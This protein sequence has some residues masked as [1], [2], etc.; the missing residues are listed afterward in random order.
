MERNPEIERCIEELKRRIDMHDLADR[1]GL[2]RPGG[3]GNYQNPLRTDANPSLSIY[4]KD[5]QWAF[6]DHATGEGSTTIDLVMLVQGVDF[7][8]ACKTLCD[9]YT[10]PWPQRASEP[11]QPKSRAQFIAE[12]CL[13]QADGVINYLVDVRK[14]PIETVRFAIK[15]RA[16]GWNTWTSDKVPAGQPGHGGEAAAFIVR[17]MNPGHIVAVDM[18]YVDPALN[19]KVKTQCQ[20]EKQGQVWTIDPRRLLDAKVVYLVESSINAL[21]VEA[22][23]LPFTAAAAVLGIENIAHTDFRWLRG[24]AVRICFDNDKPFADGPKAGR[25]AGQEAAWALHEQLTRLDIAAMMVDQSEWFEAGDDDEKVEPINDV[26]DLLKKEGPHNLAKMLRDAEPWLIQGMPGQG[27]Q[28][29]GRRR[30]F[31]PYHD[32][33]Q[34]DYYRVKEDFTQAFTE[35]VT[36]DDSGKEIRTPK[37]ED[38]AGF[39]IAAL[40]RVTIASYVATMTGDIDSQPTTKFAISVQVP[41][42]GAELKRS[43]LEDD[44]LHNVEVWKKF[45]PVFKQT[46]FL[47]MVN[48]LERAAH[49]GQRNACN[50]V[51][52]AYK[53]GRL[54]LNE[55]PDC[56]FTSPAQQCRYNNLT[57]PS[58]SVF[59]AR[60]VIEAYQATFKGNPGTQMLTWALGGHMKVLLGFWPHLVLQAGKGS[61]KSTFLKRLEQTIAFTML[62]GQSLQ[63]EY[64]MLTSISHTSH[65]IGWEE[66][67]ARKVEIIDKAVAMLQESYQY[68]P[69]QRGADMTEYLLSAP[70]LLAGEDV[71]V[72]SL[73]GKITRASITHERKGP[74]LPLDLPRFPVRQWILFLAEQKRPEILALYREIRERLASRSMAK[75]DDPGATRMVGNYAAVALAWRLLCEFAGIDEDAGGF[76]ADL[77]AEMNAHIGETTAEREPW[78]W[79]VEVLLSEIASNEFR[80]PYMFDNVRDDDGLTH[81]CLLVRTGFVIDH[82]RSSVRLRERWNSMPIKSNTVFKKALKHAGV[83]VKDDIE[84][85]IGADGPLQPGRRVAHMTALSIE[86][87]EHFGLYAVGPGDKVPAGPEVM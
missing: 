54:Q 28:R 75:R 47:R 27:K 5:G 9:W 4:E 13:A 32:M 87:L 67:S 25:C 68:T 12:K 65:P 38:L 42:H 58:G 70:V 57:F 1:L 33:A 77:V 66:L 34:Y 84:R 35:K 40:S 63:T 44:K 8:E 51:G 24:K 82:L 48:I 73:I 55:G 46:Q 64:R 19:G 62:S 86:R 2:V 31:L 50:F 39:R 45:G 41:R 29:F 23:N 11:Q 79:I 56:Y 80:Y 72:Q 17:S 59:D 26:N 3:K 85:A 71:P 15:K 53:E 43:V 76:K 21:S 6:K 30:V 52:L 18:R 61:G 10:I 83:V 36:E 14:I 37:W 81:A 16:I 49:L 20:G 60:K 22:A 7:I 74:E 78:V 69:T